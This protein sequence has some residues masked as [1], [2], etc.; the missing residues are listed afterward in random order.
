MDGGESGEHVSSSHCRSMMYV[1][2]TRWIQT[3]R[4]VAVVPVIWRRQISQPVSLRANVTACNGA[5]LAWKPPA[6]NQG[7]SVMEAELMTA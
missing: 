1:T 5:S 6:R 3:K 7:S 2:L 4:R